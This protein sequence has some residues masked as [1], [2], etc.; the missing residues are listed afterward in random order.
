[1]SEEMGV[2]DFIDALS[3]RIVSYLENSDSPGKVVD[4][5][6]ANSLRKI[7]DLKLPLEGRGLNSV[8]DDIDEYLRLCVKTNRAGFMNP[9]WGG[10]SIAGFAG[11][12]IANLSNTSMYTYELAPLATLIEQTI[13]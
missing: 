10:L 9:L 8:L 4:F 7:S 5:L 13:I 6:P 12:V 2:N 1:M 3:Q 11:E